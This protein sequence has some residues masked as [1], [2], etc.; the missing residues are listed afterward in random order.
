VL[1][2]H[3][4]GLP[5]YVEASVNKKAVLRELRY[6]GINVDQDD[7]RLPEGVKQ[8]KGEVIQALAKMAVHTLVVTSTRI[9]K[10]YRWE[11]RKAT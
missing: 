11:R 3:R 5:I 8:K 10:P 6:F 9:G 2:F 4:H 7:I 1:D